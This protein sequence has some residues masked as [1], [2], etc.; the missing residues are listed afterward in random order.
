[1]EK[2]FDDKQTTKLGQKNKDI[3]FRLLRKTK[4]SEKRPQMN[5]P[6]AAMIS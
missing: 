3:E 2:A 6:D 1:M 4:E 5:Q